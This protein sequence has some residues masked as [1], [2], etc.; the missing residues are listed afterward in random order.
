MDLAKLLL[1]FSVRINIA[2]AQNVE[3]TKLKD[4][5]DFDPF[6]MNLINTFVFYGIALKL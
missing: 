4:A 2:F 3:Q 6:I 5:S 1:I